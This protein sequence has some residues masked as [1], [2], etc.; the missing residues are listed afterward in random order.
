MGRAIH[1]YG[2]KVSF[3]LNVVSSDP[4]SDTD[5]VDF[6]SLVKHDPTLATNR[7]R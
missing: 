6:D 7:A 1:C 4:S 5:S 3:M 2:K